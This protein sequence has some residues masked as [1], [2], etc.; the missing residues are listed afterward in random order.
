[1]FFAAE[2]DRD[3]VLVLIQSRREATQEVLD[4]YLS[5]REDI[6]MRAAADRRSFLMAATLDN[7]IR[8]AE[9]ELEWLNAVTEYLP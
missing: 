3:S 7:G 6:D 2:L 1:V 8:H 4:D 9:A 5:Q